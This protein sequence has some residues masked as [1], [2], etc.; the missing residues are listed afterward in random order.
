[1][2]VLLLNRLKTMEVE[3]KFDNLPLDSTSHQKQTFHFNCSLCYTK[4]TIGTGRL[5]VSL[6]S[7][8]AVSGPQRSAVCTLS[9]KI[10]V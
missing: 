9:R 7:G 4:L 10:K 2:V 5:R 8:V 6:Q 1:M 3:V